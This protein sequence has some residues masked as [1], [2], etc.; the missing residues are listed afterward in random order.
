MEPLPATARAFALLRADGDGRAER[1]LRRMGRE[2]ESL[3]P[4][5]VGI[6]LT[7]AYDGLTLTLLSGDP[8]LADATESPA[9]A[10]SASPLD[11]GRW[12]ELARR[13]PFPGVRSSLYLPVIDAGAVI[14]GVDL[15]AAEPHAFVGLADALATPTRGSAAGAVHDADLTFRTRDRAFAAPWMLSPEAR[16]Q[17]AAD[18]VARLLDVDRDTA[19]ERLGAVARR[20]DTTVAEVARTVIVFHG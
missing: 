1:R 9:S 16:V 15:Y 8:P 14:A 10:G 6:S 18:L 3:V 13:D 7:R 11:E 2:V 4:S 17:R 12:S 19:L 5:A 20:T